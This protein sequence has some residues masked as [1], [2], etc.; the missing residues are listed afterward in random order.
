[1]NAIV[2]E[3]KTAHASASLPAK[4]RDGTIHHLAVET[5]A[6]PSAHPVTLLIRSPMLASRPGMKSC[7][8]SIPLERSAADS[9]A[10]RSVNPMSPKPSPSGTKSNTLRI[11]SVVASSPQKTHAN[12][13]LVSLC[14][15]GIR[16]RVAM[17]ASDTATTS[18]GFLGDFK[19]FLRRDEANVRAG[20]GQSL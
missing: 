5:I 8:N 1:M 3:T 18:R 19:R 14:G 16:V 6:M 12:E 15:D 11:A 13:L 7:R 10:L 4:R 2:P 9:I 20:L 17:T